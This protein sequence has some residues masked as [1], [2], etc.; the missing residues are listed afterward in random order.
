MTFNE[1][2]RFDSGNVRRRTGG[3][4]GAMIGGGGGLVVLLLGLLSTQLLGVDVTQMFGPTGGGGQQHEENLVCTGADAN[5]NRDCRIEGAAVTLEQYWADEAQQ[6]GVREY[7][8]PTVVIYDGQTNS[9]CGTA[10][11]A[12]GP[13]YCPADHGIYIDTSFFDILVDR[14]GA[15][16]GPLAE[17]YVVAHEWGHHVQNL[18]GDLTRDRQRD[19]GPT[20]GLVRLELQADCYAGAWMG[21]A[22]RATDE[23][24]NQIM[25][26]PTRD[27]IEQTISAAQAI[28]DDSIMEQAGMEVQPEKFTHGTS[29]QRTTWLMRGFEGGVQQCDTFSVPEDKL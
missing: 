11:N 10:S 22:S 8:D 18:S 6:V 28:G 3:G 16:G 15:S 23:Q 24:G 29:E 25:K 20:G 9:G 21:G 13:F 19:A 12:V 5:A 26:E 4:R 1:G 2:S 27:E 14:F 7:R 17:M